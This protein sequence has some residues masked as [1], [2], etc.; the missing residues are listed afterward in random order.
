MPNRRQQTIFYQGSVG[1]STGA[2][3][4]SKIFP[5]PFEI[6]RCHVNFVQ[7]TDS[8]LKIYL[9]ST[10]SSVTSGVARAGVPGFNILGSLMSL[11]DPYLIG[12]SYI[13]IPVSFTVPENNYLMCLGVNSDTNSHSIE[14]R[15]VGEELR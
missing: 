12:D 1:A 3:I 10:D 5:Y 7:G 6:S 14:C 9:I 11:S 4:A 8:T 2:V 13:E 15:V